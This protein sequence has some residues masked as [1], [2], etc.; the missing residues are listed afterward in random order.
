MCIYI[1]LS[2]AKNYTILH[3]GKQQLLVGFFDAIATLIA[4]SKMSR[5]PSLVLAE[6]SICDAAPIFWATA[7]AC[8]NETGSCPFNLSSSI[9][10]SSNLLTVFNKQIYKAKYKHTNILGK[11]FIRGQLRFLNKNYHC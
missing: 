8:S 5:M 10:C 11:T 3:L 6:H 7:A 1:F 4:S 9:V 2:I